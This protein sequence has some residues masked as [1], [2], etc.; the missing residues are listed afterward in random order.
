[1]E[2]MDWRHY[3]IHGIFSRINRRIT[4]RFVSAG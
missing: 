2:V 1:M 4:G 3:L